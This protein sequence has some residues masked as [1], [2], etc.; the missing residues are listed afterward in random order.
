MQEIIR[1]SIVIRHFVG[2]NS[3][4]SS[5]ENCNI[6]KKLHHYDKEKKLYIHINYYLI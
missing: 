5:R 3:I 1:N 4:I 2:Y 6:Q